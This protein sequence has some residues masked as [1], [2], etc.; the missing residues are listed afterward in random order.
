MRTPLEISKSA[1]STASDCCCEF[2]SC[3]CCCSCSGKNYCNW[4]GIVCGILIGIAVIVIGLAIFVSTIKTPSFQVIDTD[5]N[6]NTTSK[7][8]YGNITVAITNDNNLAVEFD[9]NTI[10]AFYPAST[11]PSTNQ[12]GV[13]SLER[14]RLDA[15]QRTVTTI[16]SLVDGLTLDKIASMTKDIVLRQSVDVLITSKSIK[17]KT[18]LL[19]ITI[20]KTF[21]LQCKVSLKVFGKSTAS[22]S[23]DF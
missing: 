7:S 12:L 3:S 23:V 21:D 1:V 13:F 18:F 4:K 17:A 22:C 16:Q 8:I 10:P 14:I 6:L 20:S 19:G 2:P 15:N 11:N 5:M 9:P